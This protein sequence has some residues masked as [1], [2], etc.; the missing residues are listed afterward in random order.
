MVTTPDIFV[1]AAGRMKNPKFSQTMLFLHS[2]G[3][4]D[5]LPAS[6]VFCHYR[7]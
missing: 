5:L 3:Y 7:H 4:F 2:S 1:G 6:L